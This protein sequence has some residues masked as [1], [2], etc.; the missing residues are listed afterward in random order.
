MFFYILIFFER[1]YVFYNLK[2]SIR[3][4]VEKCVLSVYLRDWAEGVGFFLL[5]RVGFWFVVF[6]G[7][8]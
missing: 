1:F 4:V 3:E 2:V 5:G 8:F 7:R 6:V